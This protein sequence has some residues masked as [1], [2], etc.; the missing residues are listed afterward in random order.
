M[1]GVALKPTT[2][3]TNLNQLI[4]VIGSIVILVVIYMAVCH[5]TAY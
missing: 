5:V 3:S 2:L 4:I 1:A